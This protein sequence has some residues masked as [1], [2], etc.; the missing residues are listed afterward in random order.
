[1]DNT[2]VKR[3]A[4]LILRLGLGA[5]ALFLFHAP[6]AKAQDCCP[7]AD[8]YNTARPVTANASASA[9]KAV[10]TGVNTEWHIKAA[11][12]ARLEAPKLGAAKLEAIPA[13]ETQAP[14]KKQSN[15]SA[16]VAVIKQPA[17]NADKRQ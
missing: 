10:K 1:M 15:Q 8:Q 2:P 7:D 4:H 13:P 17:K 16:R 11:L 5:V 12:I 6:C 9:Q 3:A 14:R